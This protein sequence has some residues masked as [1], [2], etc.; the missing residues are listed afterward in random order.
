M[1]LDPIPSLDVRL[2]TDPSSRHTCAA[3]EP[4][5]PRGA[6]SGVWTTPSPSS[7]SSS[8][9]IQDDR[10]TH[11]TI[12]RWLQ[13]YCAIETRAHT[14][15]ALS[16]FVQTALARVCTADT[17]TLLARMERTLNTITQDTTDDAR[18]QRH[19][20]WYRQLLARYGL[21]LRML[22]ESL[23]ESIEFVQREEFD[24]EW[25]EDHREMRERER[26][27]GRGG[28]RGRTGL[29]IEV[30]ALCEKVQRTLAL[31]DRTASS[32]L[33]SLSLIESKRAIREAESVTKLTELAFFFI[34][35]GFS[36]SIFGMQLKVPHLHTSP[37]LPSSLFL[38]LLPS[39]IASTQF[40]YDSSLLT[41]P[42]R[43]GVPEQRRT[44]RLD[45]R[46]PLRHHR[47][48]RRAPPHPQ[49]CPH[50]LQAASPH[51]YPRPRRPARRH[52]YP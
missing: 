46:S 18:V 26:R 8:S 7:L 35:L 25:G 5:A 45:R 39:I 21:L 9:S 34:P 13:E 28:R 15:I 44:N 47:L 31:T 2:R 1:L 30:G 10:T 16:D 32:L 3:Y 38:S 52:T 20:Q 49:L 40:Q 24:R 11:G 22:D 17:R 51:L 50:L 36:A 29:P 23:G 37:P 12:L 33:A 4:V 27:G 43:P 42:A 41:G 6:Y 14:P 19:L 48:L